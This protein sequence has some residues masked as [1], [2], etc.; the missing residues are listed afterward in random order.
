MQPICLDWILPIILDV[1]RFRSQLCSW[2]A[3]KKK[4]DYSQVDVCTVLTVLRRAVAKGE[5]QVASVHIFNWNSNLEEIK[6]IY[7]SCHSH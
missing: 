5:T 2:S 3:P 1:N 7:D 4:K 6:Y